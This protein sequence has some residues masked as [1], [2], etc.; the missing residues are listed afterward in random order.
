MLRTGRKVS[1]GQVQFAGNRYCGPSAISIVTGC[2]TAEAAFEIR[3]A[4]G[5]GRVIGTSRY[6]MVSALGQFGIRSH[7]HRTESGTK[8]KDYINSDHVM[9]LI[10][11]HERGPHWAVVGRGLYCCGA[12]ND[13]KPIR[14]T[15]MD[16]PIFMPVRW[17]YALEGTICVPASKL[18]KKEELLVRRKARRLA[19]KIGCTLEM[20]FDNIWVWPPDGK[21]TECEDD[22]LD[23]QRLAFS[24]DEVIDKLEIYEAYLSAKVN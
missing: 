13:G 20:D 24:W 3:M 12:I 7:Y 18:N 8:V 16:C 22:P 4:A 2:T 21:Y 6:E 15:N 1:I 11:T 17:A 9:L 10:V 5:K 14:A 23:G 19:K